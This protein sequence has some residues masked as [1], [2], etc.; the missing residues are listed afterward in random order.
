LT[1]RSAWVLALALGCTS[2]PERSPK[3]DAGPDGGGSFEPTPP[4]APRTT[5]CP[6]GWRAVPDP[7]AAEIIACDPWPEGGAGDCAADEAHFPG[8]PGCEPIGAVCPA[9]DYADD[10]PAAGVLYVRAGEPA[11]GDGTLANPFSR[12]AEA[13]AAASD[14]D[15]V[16]L[17]KGT[18]DEIVSISRPLTLWGACV[19]DTVVASSSATEA[20]A[21]VTLGGRGG[22]VLRDLQISGARVGVEVSGNA[23]PCT[24]RSVLVDGVNALGVAVFYDGLLSA[25]GLVV[26]HTRSGAS[27]D[28]GMGL[29]IDSGGQVTLAGAVFEEN[30]AESIVVVDPGSSLDATDLSVRDTQVRDSDGGVGY[31]VSVGLGGAAALERAVIETSTVLGVEATDPDTR[32]V[33]S[34]L[35]VRDTRADP[36]GEFGYGIQIRSGATAEVDRG[37]VE[38]NRGAQIHVADA[39]STLTAR[40]LVV[41]DALSRELGWI[42]GHGLEAIGGS[43]VTFER[44]AF[45]RNRGAAIIVAEA[46]SSLVASD[47]RVGDTRSTESRLERGYGL[48]VYAGA[49]ADV[50]RAA[51][52]QNRTVGILAF[53]EGSVATFLDLV[54]AGTLPQECVDLGCFPGGSGI[55]S[56]EGARVAASRFRISDN[57]FCGV[58]IAHDGTMDLED[59]VISGNQTGANVQTSGF[60]TS[61]LES[62]VVYHDN[63]NDFDSSALP[64]PEI[65]ALSD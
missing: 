33:A 50:T 15:V 62:G 55:A 16:A 30:R 54:V 5:P 32:I 11:G 37:L 2:K 19:R 59:G 53:D 60:D 38:R 52:V 49:S 18:F 3:D 58:Q 65:E 36:G 28:F 29:Q 21:T 17:S 57:A 4:E 64:L 26:R 46:G 12:I 48:N 27:G 20:A 31:G 22:V 51:F 10:L 1:L 44:A 24:L 41:R 39:G 23:S 45:E 8:R 7:D 40:D 34:D 43:A 6:D 42:G 13:V 9:G 63:G 14:G 56:M 35:V 61:R 47:L 25:D